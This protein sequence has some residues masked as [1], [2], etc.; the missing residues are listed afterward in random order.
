MNAVDADAATLAA[1]TRAD[2]WRIGFILM[3]SGRLKKEDVVKVVQRQRETGERFGAAA[4]ELGFASE[5]DIRFALAKQFDYPYVSP[6]E[7]KFSRDLVAAYEPHSARAE[8][9][10]ALRSQIMPR[11]FDD[12]SRKA[13]AVV[14]PDRGCGRSWLAANLAI[15]FSQLGKITVL[16]D[17]D[18]RHPVQHQL[19]G[20]E[21]QQGLSEIL[22]ARLLPRTI[23]KR[24]KVLPNLAIITAG[25]LPPN[26][27]EIVAR[28]EFGAL[29]ESLS[30]AAD[31]VIVDTPADIEAKDGQII[32]KQSGG[33][34]L[35]ARRNTSRA[36]QISDCV[37]NLRAMG[38][39]ML[40]SVLVD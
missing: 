35:V 21:N 39:T 10:R 3:R 34:L 25:T 24:N 31:V 12:V 13:L 23:L 29:V 16:I 33:A 30:S 11:W 14:G 18:L 22:S 27:Q 8:S 28:P 2:E 7:S 15:T 9:L 17:G 4:M 37:A 36:A 6:G 38:T 19:F 32:A 20:L 26:P 40:L 1:K 5:N